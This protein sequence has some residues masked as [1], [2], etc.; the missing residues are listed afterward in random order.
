V[1]ATTVKLASPGTVLVT[2]AR[3]EA[4]APPK[5]QVAAVA[6]DTRTRA[7]DKESNIRD[8]QAPLQLVHTWV[9]PV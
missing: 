7:A 1:R 5:T 4:L 2:D 6:G 8:I 3:F 9:I